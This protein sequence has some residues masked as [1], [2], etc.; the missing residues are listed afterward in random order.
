M[1]KKSFT[2]I[3]FSFVIHMMAFDAQAQEAKARWDTLNLIRQ[4]KLDIILP[5]AMRDNNID[6][7]IHIMRSWTP[8]PLRFG[9]GARSGVFIFTDRGEDRIERAG[10]LASEASKPID[11][12]R[13]SAHYRKVVVVGLVRR[14]LN[15]L[16]SQIQG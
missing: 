15:E 4:E 16:R 6:M 12:V 2:V 3:F 5:Q 14:A 13:G 8:D 9:L 11:D 7:W 1:N 10:Q